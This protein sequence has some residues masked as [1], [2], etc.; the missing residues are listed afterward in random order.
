M[1]EI[2]TVQVFPAVWLSRRLLES[3]LEEADMKVFRCYSR[4]LLHKSAASISITIFWDAV[5]KMQLD[6]FWLISPIMMR[7]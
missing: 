5:D 4:V 2:K 7:K 6:I 3:A 1:V